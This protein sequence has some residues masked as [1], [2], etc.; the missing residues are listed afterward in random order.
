MCLETA[1]HDSKYMPRGRKWF[2]RGSLKPDKRAEAPRF[3]KSGK[4]KITDESN[5]VPV[6]A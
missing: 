4:L 6:A 1:L 2:R 3:V 5:F